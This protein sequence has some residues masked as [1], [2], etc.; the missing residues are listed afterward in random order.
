[1]SLFIDVIE[2]LSGKIKEKFIGLIEAERKDQPRSIRKICETCSKYLDYGELRYDKME[3]GINTLKETAHIDSTLYAILMAIMNESLDEDQ[4]AIDLLTQLSETSAALDFK[5]ELIDF[6]TIGSFATIKKYDLLE[7]AGSIIIERYSEE[8][9]IT[10]TLSNMYLKVENDEY[11]PVIQ[12][13]LIKAREKFPELLALE[14]L[15]GF[16]QIKAKEYQSALNTFMTIKDKLLQQENEN[17]FINDNLASVWDNIAICYLK[18]GDAVKTIESCDTAIG[19][20]NNAVAY[21][22]GLNV[23]YKKAEAYL[24]AGQNENANVIANQILAENPEDE[25]ALEIK[26]RL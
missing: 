12:K 23:L 13:L 18:L 25:S 16:I 17:R 2:P 9:T 5:Q 8:N 19:Y 10:D 26:E 14:S 11:L 21:K 3:E 1:M 22:L 20:D 6:I 7:T 15:T 4:K 24:L